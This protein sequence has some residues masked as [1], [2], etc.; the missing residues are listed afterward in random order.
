[1]PDDERNTLA[2]NYP[3]VVGSAVQKDTIIGAAVTVSKKSMEVQFTD[4]NGN[5]TERHTIAL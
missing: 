5:I 3:V 4:K 2:H 1:M